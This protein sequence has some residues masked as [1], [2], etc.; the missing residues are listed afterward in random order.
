MEVITVDAL[1]S[2]LPIAMPGAEHVSLLAYAPAPEQR[3]AP[4]R[5]RVAVFVCLLGLLG[6][7]IVAT[8]IV[9]RR[10]APRY[11]S[12]AVLPMQ[13]L[14]PASAGSACVKAC[15]RTMIAI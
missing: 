8:L 12:I 7:V 13:N 11:Y 2:P 9:E 6:A 14:S 15:G 3:A 5:V 4:R 1:A 10:H